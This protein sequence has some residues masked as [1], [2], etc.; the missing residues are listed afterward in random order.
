MGSASVA[1]YGQSNLPAG[2]DL[3]LTLEGKPRQVSTSSGNVI[4]DNATELLVGIAAAVVV[5]VVAAVMIPRWRQEPAETLDRDDLI[6]AIAGLD[7]EY[8]A[9]DIGEEEYHRQREQMMAE[10]RATWGEDNGS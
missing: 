2:S 8:E 3:T 9:G 5:V 1:T 7:D 4:Q 6:Q 10:L